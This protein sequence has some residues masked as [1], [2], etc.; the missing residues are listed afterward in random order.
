MS[1]AQSMQVHVDPDT[2]CATAMLPERTG[3]EPVTLDPAAMEAVCREAGIALNDQVRAHLTS[4]LDQYRAEPQAIERVIARPINPKDGA[5]GYIEWQEG[6]DPL[7][8]ATVIDDNG[9]VDHYAGLNFIRVEEGT[10]VGTL[11][12]PTAG[13]HGHDVFG[14]PIQATPGEPVSLK[15]DETVNV[16]EAGRMTAARD[17]VITVKDETLVVTKLL[18]ISDHVDFSTGHIDFDGCVDI[19]QDVRDLFQI[20][21]SGGLSVGG[22]IEAATI[23]CD[24]NFI[25]HRG[26]VGRGRGSLTVHGDAEIGFLNTVTG[27]ISGTLTVRREIIDCKLIVKGGV[28]AEACAVIGGTLELRGKSVIGIIGSPSYRSMQITL[29]ADANLL[30]PKMLYPN[31]IFRINER[32]YEITAETKG[33]IR[34]VADTARSLAYRVADGVPR[35]LDEIATSIAEAA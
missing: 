13:T 11:H 7:A 17:G 29:D 26:M 4:M 27:T 21:S 25:G 28:I 2:G 32:Q 1:I 18:E 12:E 5:D 33:P 8:R 31:V 3:Q 10:H 35:S 34:I 24:G 6:Y 19:R 9:R 20:K 16:D 14:K 22:L 30:V 23:T 15:I